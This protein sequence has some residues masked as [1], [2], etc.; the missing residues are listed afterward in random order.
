MEKKYLD[1]LKYNF[2]FPQHVLKLMSLK[3]KNIGPEWYIYKTMWES[4]S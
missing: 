3:Q 2:R 1:R 4:R